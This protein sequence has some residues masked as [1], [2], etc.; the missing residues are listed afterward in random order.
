MFDRFIEGN[1]LP[2]C[3]EHEYSVIA[4]SPLDKGKL[5]P[6][7][8]R[9][10]H[11]AQEYGKSVSQ[12]IL[13]WLIC[14]LPVVVIPKALNA[15]HIRENS[16]ASDFVLSDEHQQEIDCLFPSEPHYIEPTLISVSPQ[17]E[18]NRKVYQTIEDALENPLNFDPSPSELAEVIKQGEPVKPVRLTPNT[19]PNEDFEYD[20]I[21]GRIRY[22]AWVIAFNSQKPVPS[23]VRN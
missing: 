19:N 20:L 7:Q 2:Y 12:V 4:Y 13:N 18:G 9:L 10:P 3:E 22:W 5:A 8:R 21:E 14:R 17:G 23:Y 6:H 15:N 11:I 16:E 1:I